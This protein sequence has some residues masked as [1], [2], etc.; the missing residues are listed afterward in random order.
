MSHKP[1][2]DRRPR[3][4]CRMLRSSA[5]LFGS[6]Q[7]VQELHLASTMHAHIM[8]HSSSLTSQAH[9]MP[10]LECR[11][12]AALVQVVPRKQARRVLQVSTAVQRPAVAAVSTE[13]AAWQ[14]HHCPSCVQLCSHLSAAGFSYLAQTWQRTA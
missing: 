13:G 7:A 1:R 4:A 6:A 5:S 3:P 11:Q 10:G 8:L 2:H 14:L 12:A 9:G